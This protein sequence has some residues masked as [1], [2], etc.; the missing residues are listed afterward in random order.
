MAFHSLFFNKF[1]FA[2]ELEQHLARSL[3]ICSVWVT[4]RPNGPVLGDARPDQCDNRRDKFIFHIRKSLGNSQTKPEGGEG[5][6]GVYK[7]LYFGLFYIPLMTSLCAA[8]TYNNLSGTRSNEMVLGNPLK[9]LCLGFGRRCFLFICLIFFFSET[10]CRLR[11]RFYLFVS[12]FWGLLFSVCRFDVDVY[13]LSG[14]VRLI[15]IS[16]WAAD[17]VSVCFDIGRRNEIASFGSSIQDGRGYW[18]KRWNIPLTGPKAD[19]LIWTA[20]KGIAMLILA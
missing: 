3:L 11:F 16:F 2:V 8:F 20:I 12:C 18:R 7:I 17:N 14:L 13:L 15:W 4:V 1:T 6:G 9:K 19:N 5:G 10:D